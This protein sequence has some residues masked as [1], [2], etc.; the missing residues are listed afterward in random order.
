[1]DG[2]QSKNN[3]PNS[4]PSN[5]IHK[6]AEAE[7]SRSKMLPTQ[8]PITG[9]SETPATTSSG[10]ASSGGDSYE[11]NKIIIIVGAIAIA[12]VAYFARG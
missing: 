1:M 8:T 7:S 6:A 9:G 2:G 4:H 11:T 12:A 10:S 3:R 5:P